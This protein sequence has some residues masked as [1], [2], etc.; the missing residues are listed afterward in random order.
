MSPGENVELVRRIYAALARDDLDAAFELMDPD[1]EY[2]NPDYAVEP[3][4]RR[5]HAGIRANVENMRWAFEFWR[6]DP[7]E[8]VEA[9]DEVIVVGTFQARG[10][11]SGA[12]T[13]RRMSR[14]WT[15]RGGMAVRYRWFNNESEAFAITGVASDRGEPSSA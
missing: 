14:I 8:Y 1:I 4:V 2:I 7:E 6:F 3:G 12:E 11:D 5:G 10:R 15:V 13:S 9:G